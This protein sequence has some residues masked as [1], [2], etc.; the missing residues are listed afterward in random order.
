VGIFGLVAAS[1]LPAVLRITHGVEITCDSFAYA[2]LL[3]LL[4]AAPAASKELPAAA[5]GDA[6][7]HAL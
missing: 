1:F 7:L 6:A 3:V 2:G 5:H 4:F